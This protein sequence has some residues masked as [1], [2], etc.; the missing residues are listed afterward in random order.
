MKIEHIRR[1]WE[2]KTQTRY[3][4]RSFYHTHEWKALRDKHRA[5]FTDVNGYRLSNIYCVECYKESK[6]KLPGS[7]ADHIVQRENGGKDELSNLQTLCST[8]HNAKSAKEGNAK[9]KKA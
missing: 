3:N 7:I 2:K 9:H 6:M 4:D 5:G 1:P 8:H